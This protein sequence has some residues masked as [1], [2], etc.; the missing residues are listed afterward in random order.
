MFTAEIRVLS[1]PFGSQ[2]FFLS[3]DF[4]QTL[5]VYWRRVDATSFLQFLKSKSHTIHDL[6]MSDRLTTL[7]NFDN[8]HSFTRQ[9]SG[10]AQVPELVHLLC[11]KCH[12]AEK[13]LSSRSDVNLLVPPVTDVTPANTKRYDSCQS[14]TSQLEKRKTISGCTAKS[15]ISPKSS[16]KTLRRASCRR[17]HWRDLHED[18]AGTPTSFDREHMQEHL[19]VVR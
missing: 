16:S 14:L 1:Y 11:G 7:V 17:H 5:T 19:K 12:G 3:I 2:P 10:A 6:T 13:H 4:S 8:V 9:L 18:P 15:A